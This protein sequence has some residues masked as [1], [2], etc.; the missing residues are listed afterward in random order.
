MTG[1]I[2]LDHRESLSDHD[3]MP[4]IA[5]GDR[6]ALTL[7][8]QQHQTQIIN[9]AYRFLVRWDLAEDAAQDAFV[10]VWKAAG[11][12]RADAKFTTWLY[13][14]VANQC[15]DRR[16]QAARELRRRSAAPIA[17]N[18]E[19]PSVLLQQDER[20]ERIR[21]AVAAL[22]D[23]QRL[24]VNMHRYEGLSHREIMEVTGWSRPAV[25]SCLVRAYE[26]LRKSLSDMV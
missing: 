20:T 14:L 4:L 6:Q 17:E 8:V 16:R 1:E 13:R 3:L 26:G 18:P 10:R 15:W 7:L 23:R 19:D 24:A 2:A 9:L 21:Q 22:P 12:F 5:E 11:T 25:E